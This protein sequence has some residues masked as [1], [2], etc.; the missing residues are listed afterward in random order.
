MAQ[1]GRSERAANP[2]SKEKDPPEEPRSLPALP[3]RD[4]VLFPH[5]VLPLT[6]G[7]DSSVQLINSLGE[8]KTIIVVAQREARVDNP[9]PTDLYTVGSLA[10]VHKVVK[11]P[12]QSLFVFAEGLERVRLT[13]FTQLTPFMR[14]RVET[15]AEAIPPKSSELEAL[16]R[17]VLTLFQQIVAGSPTLSDELS[18]VAMNI[19]E[20]GRLVDFIASSLPSLTTAD[21]QD[22]LET[23]DVRIRLEKINQHLAK[24]LEVQQLRNK[25]QSE[26]QDRVQQ[27][28][29]E[30]YLREQM[31]AI[32]KE[33]GEQDEGARDTEDLRQKIEAAGMPDEVKKEAL[34]ELG[35][36]SRMS[37]MAAD[38]SVT[39]NYIEWLAVLP[40]NKTSGV[41]VDIPKAK[42]ILDADHYD[43]KK[44]KDRILDYLSVR[45]LKPNMKGPIL[46]F[47]GP[48]GVGKTSLGKSIARALGRKFVRLSLGGVHDEAEIRGHR[49]T[50]IGA[51]PGQIIQGI[52]RAE[53]KDPVFMLDEVDKVGRDFR[54]DPGSAL[55]EALDPEQNSTFRDNYLDVAFDLSKVLFI[56]TANML[57]PIAEPLR[58]R[59]EIIELQGYTEE[60]KIH[61]A[62]QYLIPRQVEENG[63]GAEQ[64]EFP[65]A[66]I[67]NLVRHY[68]REAGVRNLERN[69]GT[70]CRKQARRLA[71][72][73]TEKLVVT[74]EVIHDFLGGIKVRT[75]GEIAERTERPGVA[76]GLAWTPTG[77]DVL[78]IEANTMKGKGGFT[79]TGQIGQVMQ[80]SMQAAL[81]WVR[82]NAR[83]LAIDEDFFAQHDIHI[84]VPAGAI[85]KDGPS[86][87]VTMA[88]ALVSLLTD[89]RVRPLTAM[90][91]EITLSGNV[92]PVGGI[93]EKVLAAKR[94]GVHDV[95]L[96][97]EN[98]MN[99]DED[100]TPEQL[101]NVNIHYVKTIDEALD[102]A[103]PSSAREEKQDAEEREKVLHT[104][105]VG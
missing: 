4:T 9:Q 33:L 98:Q 97:A 89:R 37:P 88:T 35:R 12:N 90:T 45:R 26:V 20:P 87:G 29:R 31:K 70:I 99:V 42:E 28:Q 81:T 57:D 83:Q 50:Y 6:V 19:E 51:L 34:K 76:V 92:L 64:I 102:L 103:L 25:I 79:M 47:V 40:W 59:M 54:G 7:R 61:I 52:R 48:P 2:K 100:L 62:F 15:V 18:T 10:V 95:I 78:F 27:T 32:Q 14:A 68:T 71:E 63:I 74:E 55:L 60:E 105:P 58:D 43:L 80:E 85:P 73:K 23:T 11:M 41:E 22:V 8:D 53:T 67:R 1:Q 17:N 91:G 94:A 38:Y 21:K 75:E 77:G 24:E 104:Q 13:E 56:T 3:V 96:P 49:R 39:R 101:E 82:S 46:C 16:Q 93:K 66:A 36:L 72:G 86:A 69:I 5:A 30:Y 44:V 84:H 65:E